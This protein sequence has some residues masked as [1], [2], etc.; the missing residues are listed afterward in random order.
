[1]VNNTKSSR[2][3]A[4]TAGEPAGIGAD[5]CVQLAQQL[6]PCDLVVLA[7]PDLLLQRAK[8]LRLPLK[9]HH[10]DPS[11]PT[12]ILPSG[13][14]PIFPIALKAPAQ[15]GVLN[16]DNSMYVLELLDRAVQGCQNN[17]FSS[18]LTAPVNKAVIKD[19]GL[20]FTGHTEYIA[21]QTGGEPVMMLVTEGLRVA[22]VTT[23]LPLAEVTNAITQE[24]LQSVI[25]I[26]NHDLRTRFNIEN[27]SI[28]VC[29]LNPHA[30]ESG[31][32]GH[33]EIEI[34]NPVLERLRNSGI[35]VKGTLPADTVFTPKHLKDADVVLA[36]YHD[37]G[38][39]I[40]KNKGFGRA[41][42][43]T[44]GL[45]IVRTSVDHG[46]ALDIAGKGG[47]NMGSLIYALK[48]AVSMS[49]VR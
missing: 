17:L 40:L 9:L 31:H 8:Q 10:Y 33:E 37:Q 26:L 36:M 19:A 38:L 30:G 45:P 25:S 3:V 1:M 34:I 22:L 12:E 29:G 46:T 28:L 21:Q 2:P 44:L 24:R 39:P 13:T 11:R 47:A 43:I 42:N 7:D 27:P 23:H 4:I 5:L 16:P 35:N 49:R 48:M 32:L 15:A 6:L 20:V 18:L 41:A 14:L